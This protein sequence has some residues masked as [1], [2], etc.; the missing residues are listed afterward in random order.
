V[1]VHHLPLDAEERLL[2]LDQRR[3]GLA[4]HGLALTLLWK[5]LVE[6]RG[7]PPERLWKALCWGPCR[8]LGL[9]PE[10]LESGSRRWLLFDPRHRWRWGAQTCRSLG[11]NQP[12]WDRSLEGAVVASGLTDP[13]GWA[14][15]GG[16]WN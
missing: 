4:G 2:P 7:W 5:E 3:P 16:P 10:R 13:A 15:P 12:C 11:A 6:R 1:A 14:L 8:F 9:P